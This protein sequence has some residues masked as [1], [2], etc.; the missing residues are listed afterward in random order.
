MKVDEDN[1]PLPPGLAE[2]I[3][4]KHRNGATETVRLK[5]RKEQA[6]FLDYDADDYEMSESG[7]NGGNA[8]GGEITGYDGPGGYRETYTP[9]RGPADDSPF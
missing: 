2:F 4:A 5:F 9:S 6:R 7:M 1:I 8:H 3:I